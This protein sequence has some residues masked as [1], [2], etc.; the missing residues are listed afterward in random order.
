MT[1]TESTPGELARCLKGAANVLRLNGFIGYAGD[2]DDA[3]TELRRLDD[4][5]EALVGEEQLHQDGEYETEM[6]KL[7]ARNAELEELN[8]ALIIQ[9][10]IE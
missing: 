3:V 4:L 7:R 8:T 2:V 10:P 1:K 6:Q 9:Q 5:C